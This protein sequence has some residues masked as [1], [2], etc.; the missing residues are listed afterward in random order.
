MQSVACSD[1]LH[2]VEF[3]DPNL[4]A[5]YLKA[6]SGSC[7]GYFKSQRFITE[8]AF[9]NDPASSTAVA[10]AERESAENVVV[11]SP[12][13][14]APAVYPDT[15]GLFNA[16]TR[17]LAVMF[18][19]LRDPNLLTD[20]LKMLSGSC[21][22]NYKPQSY[23]IESAFVKD[24]TSLS[25]SAAA[26]GEESADNVIVPAPCTPVVYTDT[27]A[28]LSAA[29]R[30]LTIMF[31]IICAWRSAYN[32]RRFAMRAMG[33]DAT[34][35]IVN[36]YLSLRGRVRNLDATAFSSNVI[37]VKL[38]LMNYVTP[39][40]PSTT[41]L[42]VLQDLVRTWICKTRLRKHKQGV[43]KYPIHRFRKNTCGFV[44][45]N[46]KHMKRFGGMMS[47]GLARRRASNMPAHA[48]EKPTNAD[49]V[50]CYLTRQYIRGRHDAH[51][52][53]VEDYPDSH[54]RASV[55]YN[56]Q[57]QAKDW[58][59][60]TK[61]AWRFEYQTYGTDQFYHDVHMEHIYDRNLTCLSRRTRA[62]QNNSR[63]YRKRYMENIEYLERL[64]AARERRKQR[65]DMGGM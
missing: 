43:R 47:L 23:L 57:L 42:H 52:M 38:D 46:P 34:L 27:V 58:Y 30:S 61:T 62:S 64:L 32:P 16:D 11:A 36:K 18:D 4:M 60:V 3:H 33:S 13:L 2:D 20:Y 45:V 1:D 49:W 7:D 10:H 17:S 31:D 6:F 26:P 48:R 59:G 37:T 55:R 39:K 22:D 21:D 40:K 41:S 56:Q 54:K 8:S 12:L 29:T 53:F 5:D 51:D 63:N 50:H 14:S 25:T 19:N 65:S 35:K 15:A 9:L 28:Q 24:H 44:W